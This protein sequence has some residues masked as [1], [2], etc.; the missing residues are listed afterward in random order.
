MLG[1]YQNFHMENPSGLQTQGPIQAAF[2]RKG[3]KRCQRPDPDILE[4]NFKSA[5]AVVRLSIH[6]DLFDKA[7]ICRILYKAIFDYW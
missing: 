5:A 7:V 3:W 2:P 1:L 4:S 6:P